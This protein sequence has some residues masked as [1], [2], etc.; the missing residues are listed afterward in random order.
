M[1]ARRYFFMVIPL[2]F[3]LPFI[4]EQNT[5]AEKFQKGYAVST[6]ICT[7]PMFTLLALISGTGT[8]TQ[9]TSD[10]AVLRVEEI[11]DEGIV[12]LENQQ[13]PLSLAPSS[14]INVFGWAST[15]P[16]YGGTGSGALNDAYHIVSLLEGLQNA[17]LKT[18][19]EL[20]S[21]YTNY[22]ADRPAVDM[23]EQDWTLPEPAAAEG[24][25]DYEQMVQ[26]PFGHG[27]SYTTFS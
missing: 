17:G 13:N 11:A 8:L 20:S 5:A 2:S 10:A 9:E 18:N 1:I 16:V 26:Y 19:T 27:L 25:I 15:N 14:N 3:Q 23:F 12:L 21:F 24:F 7:G 4:A 22:R 6:L